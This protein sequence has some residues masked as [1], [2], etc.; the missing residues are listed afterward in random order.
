MLRFLKED[1]MMID[2]REKLTESFFGNATNDELV[3][4]L[5]QAIYTL[6]GDAALA[7]GPAV[8]VRRRS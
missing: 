8:R 7:H 6:E 5:G 4:L 2:I 3:D 1:P